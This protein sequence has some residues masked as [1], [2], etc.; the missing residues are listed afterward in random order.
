LEGL[1]G[2][3]GDITSIFIPKDQDDKPIG[4]AFINFSSSIEAED[5]VFKMNNKKI[6]DCI[7]YVNRA[8]KKE[9]R[10]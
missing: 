1:F 2:V 5:A 4:F 6:G 8:I 3:F 9:E 7:L 10:E